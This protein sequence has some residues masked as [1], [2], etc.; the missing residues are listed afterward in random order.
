MKW[1][2]ERIEAL[3]SFLLF[4][5]RAMLR[6]KVDLGMFIIAVVLVICAIAGLNVSYG[7]GLYIVYALSVMG[8]F[9]AWKEDPK[10]IK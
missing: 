9:Q 6:D 3:K 4:M 10:R 2:K 8:R 7:I 1:F 5:K